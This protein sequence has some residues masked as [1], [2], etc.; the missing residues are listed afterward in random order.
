MS[1]YDCLRDGEKGLLCGGL[2]VFQPP[3]VA[4][5]AMSILRPL[6]S[7]FEYKNGRIAAPHMAMSTFVV[8]GDAETDDDAGEEVEDKSPE[9]GAAET[10]PG[11]SVGFP[12][13]VPFG[14]VD[15]DDGY[16]QEDG[17]GSDRVVSWL[18]RDAGVR[19]RVGEASGRL[20]GPGRSL[21]RV[22]RCGESQSG[23]SLTIRPSLRG[24]SSITSLPPGAASCLKGSPLR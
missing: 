20:G 22:R 23:L 4:M 21:D 19:G 13:A 1:N 10:E 8:D 6:V 15:R 17:N 7:A 3:V 5:M 18:W 11:A 24:C 2:R 14:F 16:G 12:K 9:E